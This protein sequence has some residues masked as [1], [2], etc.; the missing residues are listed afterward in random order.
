MKKILF[1]ILTLLAAFTI[2]VFSV[3]AKE[4]TKTPES[5]TLTDTTNPEETTM[6]RPITTT[7]PIITTRP[8]ATEVTTEGES[9]T[10]I[11]ATETVEVS[12][13]NSY[14]LLNSSSMSG[15]VTYSSSNPSVATVTDEGIVTTIAKGTATITAISENGVEKSWIFIVVDNSIV[16]STT[17]AEEE[18]TIKP[19]TCDHEYGKWIIS[20]E[21]TCTE[22]GI[23]YR[24]CSKCDSSVTGHIETGSVKAFGHSFGEGVVTAPT[25]GSKGYTTYTC[26]NCGGTKTDNEVPAL[27]HT[28]GEE[29]TVVLAPT[30]T[31]AGSKEKVCSNCSETTEGH[32]LT[33][34]IPALG[35][36]Y[37]SEVIAPTYE[38][39]GYTL[40]TC[41]VCGHTEEDTYTDPLNGRV[42]AVELGEKLVVK[43]GEIGQLSPK[44]TMDGTVTYTVTYKL[45]DDNKDAE[46][47]ATVDENGNVTGKGMGN[48]VITCTVTD[49]YGNVVTD[50]VDVQ[51]KFS[52][53]NW[54]QILREVLKAAIDIV[55]GG[56]DF[57]PIK[58]LFGGNK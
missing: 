9:T 12:V 32:V 14:Q 46:K 21:E 11:I 28:Y 41:S 45:P 37:T 57:G 13:D 53:A 36:A 8:T 29:W 55:I 23:K 18:T 50:T 33:E 24:V 42:K 40:R 51:V 20:Q 34:S 26:A 6:V 47:I 39:G 43:Y 19:A 35:H 7:R 58:D 52:L 44:V 49:Q 22:N 27:Q 4:M 17:L 2:A 3:N 54:F 31:E 30:C 15:K 25:C 1:L 16:E 10:K 48:T 38:N 56:L 5:V